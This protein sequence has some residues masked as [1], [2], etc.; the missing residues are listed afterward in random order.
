MAKPRTTRS[1]RDKINNELRD[2]ITE[3]INVARVDLEALKQRNT[4]LARVISE[5]VASSTYRDNPDDLA[6]KVELVMTAR[7]DQS[8]LAQ[9]LDELKKD[10]K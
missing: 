5:F 6:Q 10:L 1:L 8:K 3:G 7:D 4:P 2:H 9:A